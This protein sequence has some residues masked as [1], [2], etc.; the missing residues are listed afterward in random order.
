MKSLFDLTVYIL[1]DSLTSSSAVGH[2]A[3]QGV[4]HE[5]ALSHYYVSPFIPLLQALSHCRLSHFII[6][7]F[8]VLDMPL[9]HNSLFAVVVPHTNTNES[10]VNFFFPKLSS[11]WTFHSLEHSFLWSLCSMEQL[12]LKREI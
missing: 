4:E 8:R 3:C 10:S 9:A 12:L 2:S 6:S 5:H 11:A 7:Y 1:T